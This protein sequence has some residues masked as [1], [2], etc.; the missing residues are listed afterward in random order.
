MAPSLGTS[1][2][3]RIPRCG[4]IRPIPTHG[5]ARGH[6]SD[7]P[8]HALGVPFSEESWDESEVV[9]LLAGCSGSARNLAPKSPVVHF[10]SLLILRM[11]A[12]LLGTLRR[13]PAASHWVWTTDIRGRLPVTDKN[14]PCACPLFGFQACFRRAE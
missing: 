11:C 10:L 3:S 6:R 13:S 9:L 2:D 7:G 8:E 1:G 5:S 12:A 4:A 14:R